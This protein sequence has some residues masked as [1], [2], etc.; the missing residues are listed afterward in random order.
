ML[1]DN[2]TRYIYN[3]NYMHILCQFSTNPLYWTI[4]IG[5]EILGKFENSKMPKIQNFDRQNYVNVQSG[6]FAI[7]ANGIV[8]SAYIKN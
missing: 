5:Y 8:Q 3:A 7:G 4:F 1:D 2:P 6:I